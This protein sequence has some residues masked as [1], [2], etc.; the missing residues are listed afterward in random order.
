M[1][2]NWK[3]MSV[4]YMLFVSS[5]F[6]MIWW[7]LGRAVIAKFTHGITTEAGGRSLSVPVPVLCIFCLCCQWQQELAGAEP[8]GFLEPLQ[9]DQLPGRNPFIARF[10]SLLS[11]I[12]SYHYNSFKFITKT[13]LRQESSLFLFGCSFSFFS[14]AHS[15]AP[16]WRKTGVQ[17]AVV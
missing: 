4:L 16:P 1:T 9:E 15:F 11:L 8:L 12:V 3:Y 17:E 10:I 2:F 5:C 14:S 6:A 7:V 13:F